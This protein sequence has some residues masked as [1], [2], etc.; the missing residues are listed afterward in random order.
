MA[1]KI[2]WTDPSL[3]SQSTEADVLV[4]RLIDSE[5]FRDIKGRSVLENVEA[6]KKIVP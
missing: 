1:L 4:V 6:R 2:I 3:V 5:T